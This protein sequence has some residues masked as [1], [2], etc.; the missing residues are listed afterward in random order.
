MVLKVR[1]HGGQRFLPFLKQSLRCPVMSATLFFSQSDC[2]FFFFAIQRDRSL[3]IKKERK[4]EK[5]ET[6]KLDNFDTDSANPESAKP[7]SAVFYWLLAQP[8]SL[9]ELIVSEGEVLHGPSLGLFDKCLHCLFLLE[10]VL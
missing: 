3:L 9:R 1:P 2:Q 10:Q 5:K 8:L 6:L 7:E 4:K